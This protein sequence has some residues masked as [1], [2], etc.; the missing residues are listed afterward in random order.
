MAMIHNTTAPKSTLKKKHNSIAYHFIREGV[1]RGELFVKF[2]QNTE[3]IADVLTTSL[4][5]P[6]REFLLTMV[7][8]SIHDG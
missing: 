3:N 5:Q 2:L 8:Y 4:P 1:A 7:M 6:K